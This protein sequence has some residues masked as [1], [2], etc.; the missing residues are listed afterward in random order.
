MGRWCTRL[1]LCGLDIPRT[2]P[3]GRPAYAVSGTDLSLRVQR[4]AYAVRGSAYA[5]PGTDVATRS[6]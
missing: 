3:P 1:R 4:F 6:T 5:T 2:M